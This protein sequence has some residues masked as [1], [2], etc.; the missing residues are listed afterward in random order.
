MKFRVIGLC[1]PLF[2]TSAISACKDVDTSTERSNE[3]QGSYGYAVGVISNKDFS[4]DQRTSICRLTRIQLENRQVLCRQPEKQ[5]Q[6]AGEP[7]TSSVADTNTAEPQIGVEQIGSIPPVRQGITLMCATTIS[8]GNYINN[9]PVDFF[10]PD[11]C[12]L[13]EGLYTALC[14]Y[15]FT[16]MTSPPNPGPNDLVNNSMPVHE[17]PIYSRADFEAGLRK[18]T[19]KV[20]HDKSQT[21]QHEGHAGSSKN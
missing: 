11:E 20:V 13:R 6:N 9:I 21:R 16:T 10:G 5:W 7:A 8:K 1:M 17:S 4:R 3:P 2:L 15:E 12:S 14:G 19:C 18:I